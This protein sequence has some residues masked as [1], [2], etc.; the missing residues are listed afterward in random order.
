MLSPGGFGWVEF[1]VY[2]SGAPG[3]AGSNDKQYGPGFLGTP[4]IEAFVP[5]ADTF[6]PI[7]GI[8]VWTHLVNAAELTCVPTR[9]ND[10]LAV[11][12]QLKPGSPNAIIAIEIT[13]ENQRLLYYAKT[14]NDGNYTLQPQEIASGNW[15]IQAF[16]DGDMM[17]GAAEST[18]QNITW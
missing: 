15:N 9:D 18:L 17:N 3:E 6:I 16:F 12:G 1:G 14:D 5:Y 2:P 7:G 10:L 8:D 4:T 13:S 11:S